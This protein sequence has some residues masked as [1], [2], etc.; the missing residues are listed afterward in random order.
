[1][2]TA[3]NTQMIVSAAGVADYATTSGSTSAVAT[4]Y[5]EG[6]RG[7]FFLRMCEKFVE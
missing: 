7:D 2:A 1:M 3:G 6:E 5:G 4:T